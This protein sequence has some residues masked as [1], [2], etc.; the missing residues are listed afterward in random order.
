MG[1][2]A[3]IL[4][5]KKEPGDGFLR[6]LAFGSIELQGLKKEPRPGGLGSLGPWLE[7]APIEGAETPE[8]LTPWA[9]GDRSLF[10]PLLGCTKSALFTLYSIDKV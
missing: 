10:P 8:V 3:E 6:W 2:R 1:L 7:L 5:G 4:T 9:F